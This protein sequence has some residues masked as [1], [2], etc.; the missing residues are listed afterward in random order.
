[1]AHTTEDQFNVQWDVLQSSDNAL[2]DPLSDI[3][4]NNEPAVLNSQSV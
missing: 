1:M 3:M 2:V 4:S